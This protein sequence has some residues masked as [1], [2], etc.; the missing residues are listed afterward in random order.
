ML[1]DITKL[2]EWAKLEVS[3]G[4]LI[5]FAQ[6]LIN[7]T[8]MKVA[9]PP[10]PVK[11]ILTLEEACIYLNLAKAT[12]YGMTSRNEVPFL[13]KSRKIYFRQS[14][15]EKYLLDGRRKTKDEIAEE[16]DAHIQQQKLKR[17]KR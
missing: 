16:A 17:A 14:D 7:Q 11:D 8:S 12:L 13:K 5:A 15:L 3:K 10:T 9:A 6:S 2:P 4:D 1:L